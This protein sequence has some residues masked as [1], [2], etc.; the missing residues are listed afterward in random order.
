MSSLVI[1]AHAPLLA[2]GLRDR[3]QSSHPALPILAG[4]KALALRQ[5][6]AASRSFKAAFDP[7]TFQDRA[8]RQRQQLD[9]YINAVSKPAEPQPKESRQEPELQE[10]Q[11]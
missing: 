6:S 7:G 1:A 8:E 3:L 5:A 10:E 2:A 4:S 9:E 11:E